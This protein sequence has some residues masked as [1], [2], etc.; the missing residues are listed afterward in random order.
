VRKQATQTRQN[1]ESVHVDIAPVDQVEALRSNLDKCGSDKAGRYGRVR[2]V[3]A[4]LCRH[5]PGHKALVTTR[6]D[7]EG[8][9]EFAAEYLDPGDHATSESEGK[10]YRQLLCA[11]FDLAITKV[12]LDDDFIRF[13]YHNGLLEGLDDRIKLNVVAGLRDL[14][15]LGIQQ[16]LTVIDSDLPFDENGEKFSF[17]DEEV[18]L[19]LHDEGPEGRLFRTQSW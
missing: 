9:I 1:L 18:V 15:D 2:A 13:V 11:A 4:E 19:T 5:F 12:L 6:L 3:L 8:N 10:S 7:K 16:I 14:A 17:R